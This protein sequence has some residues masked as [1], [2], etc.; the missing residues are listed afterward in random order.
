MTE[1]NV[2][3]VPKDWKKT[4]FVDKDE[5]EKLYRKSVDNPDKFWGKAG[6]RLDWIK[7]YTSVKNTSYE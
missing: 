7:P 4:A 6:E 2:Y 1:E 5:Y 3:K